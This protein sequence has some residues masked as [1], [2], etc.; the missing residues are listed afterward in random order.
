MKM[1]NA[2]F[3]RRVQAAMA[4]HIKKWQTMRV[5]IV[6][7]VL[8]TKLLDSLTQ[9]LQEAAE[10]DREAAFAGAILVIAEELAHHFVGPFAASAGKGAQAGG[11]PHIGPAL[12]Q[13]ILDGALREL[14][15]TVR[16]HHIVPPGG[17]VAPSAHSLN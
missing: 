7:D 12:C 8:D 11:W 1:P 14:P 4:E 3:D 6:A 16:V 17:E 15:G 2:E 5:A 10:V 13:A 9:V